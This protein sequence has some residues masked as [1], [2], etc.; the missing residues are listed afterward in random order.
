MYRKVLLRKRL[1]TWALDGPAYVPFIGDGDIAAALYTDRTV[2]GADLDFDR[3][4]IAESRIPN[5]QIIVAD[6][7]TWPFPSLE[8]P[9][10]VADFDAYVEPYLPFRRFWE[11]A[12]KLDKLMVTFTDG[13]RQ[14]LMRT[15]SWT[16]P[17]GTKTKLKGLEKTR[18]FSAYLSRHIWPWFDAYIAPWQV[19]HRFRYLRSMMVYWGAV[20]ERR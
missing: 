17:D 15:G 3:V 10:A 1:L 5:G 2:Y 13:R 18:V 7:E 12:P 9:V 11:E 19:R 14:G 20:I 6:C 8:D 16:K 4:A